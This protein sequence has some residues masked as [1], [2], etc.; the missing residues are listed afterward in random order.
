MVPFEMWYAYVIF[1]FLHTWE[2][3]LLT[4]LTAEFRCYPPVLLSEIVLQLG[5]KKVR[6]EMVQAN[7]YEG[8]NQRL[9][10]RRDAAGACVSAMLCFS[11]S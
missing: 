2:Q 7:L 4:H 11:N 3:L 8:G 1:C 9:K 5:K 6:K 10:T